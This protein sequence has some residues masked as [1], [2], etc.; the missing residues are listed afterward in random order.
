MNFWFTNYA[1]VEFLL[2]THPRCARLVAWPYVGSSYGQKWG[3]VVPVTD[4][5]DF[6]P[7]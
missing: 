4:T 2:K 5:K 3:V 6:C 7:L 1:D